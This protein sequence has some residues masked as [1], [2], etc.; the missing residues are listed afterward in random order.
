MTLTRSRLVNRKR[1]PSRKM[2]LSEKARISKGHA[3]RG[4]VR[5]R[6]PPSLATPKRVF[7]TCHYCGFSP[8]EVPVGGACP[9]CGGYSWERFAL[10]RRLLPETQQ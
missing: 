4:Q 9:K 8:P 1:R 2:R 7:V 5:F 3:P 6:V 10:C